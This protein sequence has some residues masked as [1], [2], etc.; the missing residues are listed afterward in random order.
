MFR[1]VILATIALLAAGCTS[2]EEKLQRSLTSLYSQ[3]D[4][5]LNQLQKKIDAGLIRNAQYIKSYAKVIREQ[6]PELVEIVDL[7]AIDASSKSPAFEGLTSRLND[8]K[9]QMNSVIQSGGKEAPQLQQ[10]LGNIIYASS[11]DIYSAMLADSVNVLADMSGGQLSRVASLSKKDSLL[12]NGAEDMGAGS[13]YVGNPNYGNWQTNSSGG[14]FWEWYGKYA[15]FSSL[16]NRGPIGYGSW[17][18]NRDYS[19]Y[20]DTGRN[21]YSSPSQKVNAAQT[22]SRAKKNFASQGRSFNSPYAKQKS[23]GTR[24]TSSSFSNKSSY[25]S[26][27]SSASSSR[28]SS[29]GGK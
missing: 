29:T 14:S 22:E 20:H 15:L 24:S 28:S 8:A 13:Q 19:Y 16:F 25:N 11:L 6:K 3:A 12:A 9:N 2:Q 10:E 23:S 18:S 1:I 27:T 17:A 7:V 26:R 5:S 4:S 21:Y